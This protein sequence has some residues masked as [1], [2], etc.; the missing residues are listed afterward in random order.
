[1]VHLD[2]TQGQTSIGNCK[3]STALLAFCDEE[4]QRMSLLAMHDLARRRVA[5]AMRR[6]KTTTL[7]EVEATT[8]QDAEIAE[9]L[10]VC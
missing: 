7:A 4:V 10:E 5:A 1:M 2:R 9:S 6:F 3:L 8:W